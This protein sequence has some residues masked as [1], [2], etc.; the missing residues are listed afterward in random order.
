[1]ITRVLLGF[2]WAALIAGFIDI[3]VRMAMLAGN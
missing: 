2:F 3:A 1:M